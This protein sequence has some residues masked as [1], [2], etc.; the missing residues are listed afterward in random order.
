[1]TA[2]VVVYITAG[3]LALSAALITYPPPG[4]HRRP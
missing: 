1:M 3:I 4:K 2:Y